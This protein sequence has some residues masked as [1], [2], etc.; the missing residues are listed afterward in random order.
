MKL[1]EVKTS[2]HIKAFHQLPF[3]IYR[4]NSAWV[5]HLK[6]D[7]EKVFD[8]A[9]N[10]FFRH[11]EAIRWLLYNDANKVIGRVAAFVHKKTAKSFKQPTGGLGFFECI[12]DQNA[13][14]KLFDACKIWLQERGMEAMDGP[15]N[16][17]EKDKFWG[18]LTENFVDPPYYGQNYN[19]EYYKA[20]FE[21]YGF[22][23]YYHQLVFHRDY[24]GALQEKF[25]ERANRILKN[26][27]YEIRR[28]DKRNLEK[29]ALDFH[30]IYNR[31]W[32]THD[33]FPGMSK[34]QCLAL[35]KQ[36][37]PIVDENLIY[38][39]YYDNNPVAFYMSLPE[40]NQVFRYVNGNLNWWGKLKFLWYFKIRKVVDTS[41]GVAFGVDPDH[42]G[43][44]VEGAIFKTYEDYVR[45]FPDRYKNLIITWIGDFN[46]KMIRII[47]SLGAKEFRRMA[48]Y[49]KLFDETAEFERSPIIGAR[50]PKKEAEKNSKKS[51]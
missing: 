39:A 5:P 21:N 11:G 50:R 13:A 3:S 16:F 1:V 20:F 31:A 25:V 40:L 44:G 19:P 43:K 28:I 38:F 34:A 22:Q 2:S 47:E 30:Q 51:Q 36:V 46:P 12:D 41:F 7:I 23:V 24:H 37:K 49:R 27:K 4:S 48:T 8:P 17:G 32:T 15:I 18:L 26:P 10:K 29:F 45:P 6:Q 9:Q 33:G 35:M 14:F 42:Q